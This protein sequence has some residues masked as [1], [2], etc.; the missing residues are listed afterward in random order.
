MKIKKQFYAFFLCAAATVFAGA[1][2]MAQ[3]LSGAW[4]GNLEVQGTQLPIVFH[5][6]KEADGY[7]IG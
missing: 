3:D 6:T 2:L 1:G 4:K 7:P 5:L